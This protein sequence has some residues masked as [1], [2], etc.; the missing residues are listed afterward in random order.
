MSLPGVVVV[1]GATA[2]GKPALAQAP[3]EQPP[4]PRTYAAT[5]SAA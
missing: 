3:A 4:G 5:S 1:A 2:S